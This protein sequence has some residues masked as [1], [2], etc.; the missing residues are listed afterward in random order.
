MIARDRLV[1]GW[2]D[3][4]KHPLRHANLVQGH[5]H[6]IGQLQGTLRTRQGRRQRQQ[7]TREQAQ[8]QASSDEAATSVHS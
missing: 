8:E 3:D 6:R 2:I 7:R 1:I 5:P 4:L